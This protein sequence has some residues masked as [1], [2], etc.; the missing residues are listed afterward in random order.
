MP[1]K[2]LSRAWW[3]NYTLKSSWFEFE[4]RQKL[5]LPCTGH[6]DAFTNSHAVI[7][8]KQAQ[9][10]LDDWWTCSSPSYEMQIYGRK[11]HRKVLVID[12]KDKISLKLKCLPTS[13]N[14]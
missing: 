11:T 6:H 9:F 1:A 4:P 14:P 7:K 10:I 5:L 13:K 8:Q 12:T 3:T 2:K